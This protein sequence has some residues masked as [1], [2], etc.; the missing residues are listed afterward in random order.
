MSDRVYYIDRAKDKDPSFVSQL[1]E[2]H[3]RYKVIVNDHYRT[4]PDM[5]ILLLK[6]GTNRLSVPRPS[7]YISYKEI[8]EDIFVHSYLESYKLLQEVSLDGAE[9]FICDYGDRENITFKAYLPEQRRLVLVTV[10]NTL[11]EMALSVGYSSYSYQ[12]RT[13]KVRDTPI[14]LGIF[15]Q[16]F[17]MAMDYFYFRES[18]EEGAVTAIHQI[19]SIAK[20]DDSGEFVTFSPKRYYSMVREE[21]VNKKKDL[22][23]RLISM[24]EVPAK[25]KEVRAEIRGIEYC[26]KV[27]DGNR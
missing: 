7:K 4:C 6:F 13:S 18:L 22:E 26:I 9:C 3:P 5:G 24:D 23:S 21:M 11:D 8:P 2:Q 14:Q 25:R 10:E 20:I 17:T 12:L 15:L 27:L 19:L 1:F 16:A